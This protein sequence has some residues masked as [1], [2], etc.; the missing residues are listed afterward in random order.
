M[1][2]LPYSMELNVSGEIFNFAQ[3]EEAPGLLLI[4]WHLQQT[5]ET[6]MMARNLIVIV[7]IRNRVQIFWCVDNC[8]DERKDKL[9][10]II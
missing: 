8:S 1:R 10:K 4:D 6:E 2:K 5:A 7:A 3:E 9:Y